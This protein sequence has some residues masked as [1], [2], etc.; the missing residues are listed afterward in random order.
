MTAQELIDKLNELDDKS[1]D[2][3]VYQDGAGAMD[4]YNIAYYQ[5]YIE[6]Y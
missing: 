1:I 5:D 3:C 6:L 2:V 4:I